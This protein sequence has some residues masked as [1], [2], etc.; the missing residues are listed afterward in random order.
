MPAHKAPSVSKATAITASASVEPPPNIRVD[1]EPSTRKT[2]LLVASQ[3]RPARSSATSYT[4]VRPSVSAGDR[5][6][7][8]WALMRVSPARVPTSTP[9]SRLPRMQKTAV[10]G[11]PSAGPIRLRS[12]P[13]T[14]SRPASVKPIHSVPRESSNTAVGWSLGRPSGVP[15]MVN[16]CS[17]NLCRPLLVPTHK[18]PSRSS[19]RSQTETPGLSPGALRARNDRP[20]AWPAR[21][22][23]QSTA[24]RHNRSAPRAPAPRGSHRPPRTAA[25]ARWRPRP[26]GPGWCPP[27]ARRLC[28]G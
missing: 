16:C 13:R 8:P 26:P 25:P 15:N 23:C 3:R 7:S 19:K 18:P 5:V 27:R 1:R 4:V 11:S 10:L 14:A 9:P 20:R 6:V 21:S 2:P 28:R 22:A 24:C 17:R 12:E